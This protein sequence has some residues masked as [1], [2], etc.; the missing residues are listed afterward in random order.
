MTRSISERGLIDWP[1]DRYHLFFYKNMDTDELKVHLYQSW[2]VPIFSVCHILV[3]PQIHIIGEG[4][5][6]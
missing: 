5:G 3:I 6:T 4:V 2:N 1:E